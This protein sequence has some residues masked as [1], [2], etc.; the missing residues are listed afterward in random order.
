MLVFIKILQSHL[1]WISLQLFKQPH[2]EWGYTTGNG[3]SGF[4]ISPKDPDWWYIIFSEH[5]T[6]PSIDYFR[7]HPFL[8]VIATRPVYYQK[9]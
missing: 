3:R 8:R 7:R 1:K 9:K 5:I 4:G 6:Y 2:P